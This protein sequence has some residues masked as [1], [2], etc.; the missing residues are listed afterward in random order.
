[1]AVNL[2]AVQVENASRSKNRSGVK[3]GLKRM[4]NI[5]KP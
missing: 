2:G 3:A 5:M 1:M 4:A